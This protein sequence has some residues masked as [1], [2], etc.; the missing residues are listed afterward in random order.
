MFVSLFSKNLK[1]IN[2]ITRHKKSRLCAKVKRRKR[3]EKRVKK[4]IKHPKILINLTKATKCLK[5][6]SMCLSLSPKKILNKR[7]RQKK[8]QN[9]Q[10]KRNPLWMSNRSV[11]SK[12]QKR[13]M[14]VPKI[15]I[16]LKSKKITLWR[17][18]KPLSNSK[19]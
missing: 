19:L 4:M 11:P 17:D 16:R 2:L 3:K 8:R 15:K 1:T 14:V 13:T 5:K 18:Y 7:F 10:V 9:L 6:Q 12:S